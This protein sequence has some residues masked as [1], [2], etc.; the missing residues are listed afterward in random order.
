M[1]QPLEHVALEPSAWKDSAAGGRAKPGQLIKGE[2]CLL[3]R[4]SWRW[5]NITREE[6]YA[7]ARCYYNKQRRD[8]G[9]EERVVVKEEYDGQWCKEMGLVEIPK[10]VQE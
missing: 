3:E 5:E 1:G 2:L 7:K 4:E 10:K 6:Q 9:T 8:Q